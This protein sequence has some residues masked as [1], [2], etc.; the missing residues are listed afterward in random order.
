MFALFVIAYL[1]QFLCKTGERQQMT[2]QKLCGWLQEWKIYILLIW[3]RHHMDKLHLIIRQTKSCKIHVVSIPEM[4]KVDQI[5][6]EKFWERE[7]ER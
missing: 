1:M 5:Q 6:C 3:D 2:K 7:G 4:L